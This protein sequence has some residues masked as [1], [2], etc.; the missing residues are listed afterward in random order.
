VLVVACGS[1]WDQ[2]KLDLERSLDEKIVR[3]AA[4]SSVGE[5]SESVGLTVRRLEGPTEARRFRRDLYVVSLDNLSEGPG[6][7]LHAQWT[8]RSTLR[9]WFWQFTSGAFQFLNGA[10]GEH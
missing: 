4:L 5:F 7:G 6:Y 8:F 1:G 2:G 9:A 3:G 10:A